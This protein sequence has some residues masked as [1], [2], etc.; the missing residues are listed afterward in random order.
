MKSILLLIFLILMTTVACISPPIHRS[1]SFEEK[2]YELGKERSCHV[3]EPLITYCKGCNVYQKYYV[4]VDPNSPPFTIR[5][6][7]TDENKDGYQE[8]ET[9][10]EYFRQEL[11]YSG[12]AEN[13]IN[14]S[15]REYKEQVARPTFYQDLKYDLSESMLIQFQNYRMEILDA[16][17]TGIQFKVI[18]E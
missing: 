6:K 3:G 16:N 5:Y 8:K 18:A 2:S 14:I 7:D 1:T 10:S 17:N 13:I 11:V 4:G 12:K 9:I 15:Y